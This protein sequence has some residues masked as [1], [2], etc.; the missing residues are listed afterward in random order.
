MNLQILLQ[1]VLPENWMTQIGVLPHFAI[2]D[3]FKSKDT[4][5]KQ[6]FKKATTAEERENI[7]SLQQNLAK[8]KEQ[9]Q[10]NSQG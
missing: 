1:G 4:E 7:L 9:R 3:E 8:K 2:D 5:L 10:Q 6:Q